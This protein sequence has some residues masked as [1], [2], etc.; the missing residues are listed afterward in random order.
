[1]KTH[2]PRSDKGKGPDVSGFLLIGSKGVQNSLA[3]F[4]LAEWDLHEHG[5]SRVE[6][7]LN[8]LWKAEYCGTSVFACITAN[9]FEDPQAIVQGVSEDVNVSVIPVDKLTINPDL[10]SLLHHGFHSLLFA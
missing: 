5:M 6:K 10:L 1:M 7:P 9:A 8:V 2:G 3:D 4:F